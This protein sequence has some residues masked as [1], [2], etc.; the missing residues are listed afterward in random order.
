[1]RSLLALLTLA[2]CACARADDIGDAISLY[3]WAEQ[4]HPEYFSPPS[5]GVTEIQGYLVRYYYE[6]DSYIGVIGQDVYVL[7]AAFGPGIVHAGRIAD[8]VAPKSGATVDLS[9][10]ILASRAANCSEYAGQ[11]TSSATDISR[12]LNFSGT[13]G[14]SVANGLCTFT[15]NNIPN[16]DFGAGGHFATPVSAVNHSYSMPAV[17]VLASTVTP[18]TLEWD[19]AILLNGVKVDIWAAACYGVG[20]GKIGCNNPNQAWRYDPMFSGNNFGTDTHNAHTQP[21]GAYHYHGN[22]NALFTSS[23][24][25]ASPVIGFAADGFPV[26]GSYFDD[27]GTVRKARSSYRLKTGSRASGAGNP[28]GQYDGT[29]RDDYEYVEGLGDLD[30]CNGMTVNGVYGYYVTDSFPYMMACFSGTPNTSFR[31]L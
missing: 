8:F 16:H 26:F 14:I 27:Q 17:P 15:S 9:N 23:G 20:D 13:L 21:N 31:K 4:N 29:Y 10:L 22:P 24:N 7:G 18:L 11:Y 25:A 3:T 2:C 6:T 12:S 30:A 19:N 1:M 28:G 5:Q